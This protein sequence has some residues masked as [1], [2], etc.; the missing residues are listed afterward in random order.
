MVH[1]A[2][3]TNIELTL[4]SIKRRRSISAQAIAMSVLRAVIVIGIS[5]VILFPLIGKFSISIM[6]RADMWD[7]TVSFIPS[8]RRSI[9]IGWH[10]FIKMPL[11][12][13]STHSSSP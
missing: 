2:S 13:S 7:Q 3:D 9:T 8:A 12:P 10:E 4:R 5:Y 11:R 6:T 1:T